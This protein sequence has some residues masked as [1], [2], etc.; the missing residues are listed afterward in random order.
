VSKVT[1]QVL[2]AAFS[3]QSFIATLA[4]FCFAV[5]V[6]LLLQTILLT[7]QHIAG[8]TEPEQK[9]D[10]LIFKTVFGIFFV[11]IFYLMQVVYFASLF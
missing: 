4:A 10:H 2:L 6:G 9:V 1:G 7:L 3:N 5:G 8:G 11:T